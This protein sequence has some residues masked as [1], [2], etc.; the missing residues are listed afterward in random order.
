MSV[1]ERLK[2]IRQER[3]ISQN[4]F[5][6]MLNVSRSTYLLVEKGE[7][8]INFK[9]IESLNKQF[10]VSSDWLLF[11]ES[12]NTSNNIEEEFTGVL[13]DLLKGSMTIWN[14]L[15]PYREELD[16]TNETFHEG[17]KDHAK[18]EGYTVKDFE[19]E[20]EFYNKLKILE[21]KIDN[22]EAYF[23]Y[24]FPDKIS[25][26]KR[27][28]DV[29]ELAKMCNIVALVLYNPIKPYLAKYDNDGIL[30]FWYDR[31]KNAIKNLELLDS[32]L[33]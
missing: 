19:Q 23:R 14:L 15:K 9:M 4:D 1:G 7:R 21:G 25:I 11:G 20:L 24:T 5:A 30:D 22:I 3:K 12:K 2:K 32:F 31:N 8:E 17:L 6:E 13:L 27:K 18:I 29:I 28:D 10:G 33:K 16:I 26:L